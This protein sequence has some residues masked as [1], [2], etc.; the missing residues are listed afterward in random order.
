MEEIKVGEYIKTKRQGICK[1]DHINENAPI[2][3]YWV[4][5]DCDGWCNCVKTTDVLKHSFNLIDLIEAGDIIEIEKE[6]YEV[7]YDESYEK[8]GILI[9]SRNQ[10][11]VRHSSLEF[12]FQQYKTIKILAKEQYEKHCCKIE[13]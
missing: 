11:A 4:N 9:P 2:N 3:K 10:L 8:L 5:P 13:V 6:K 7:I 12:I 1:I